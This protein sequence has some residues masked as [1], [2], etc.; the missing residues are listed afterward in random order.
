MLMLAPMLAPMFM[1]THRRVHIQVAP[2]VSIVTVRQ[3]L[4]MQAPV[5][6]QVVKGAAQELSVGEQ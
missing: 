3:L 4:L 2:R 6:G 1:T 5:R